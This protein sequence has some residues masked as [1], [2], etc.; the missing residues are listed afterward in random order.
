MKTDKLFGVHAEALQLRG[1]RAEVLAANLANVDTPGYKSRDFDFNAVLK[2][3]EP[4]LPPTVTDAGHIQPQQELVAGT[5][6][7]YR[8]PLQ[9]ALDGNTVD[10]QLE[11]GSFASNSLEYQSSLKFLNGRIQTLLLAIKGQ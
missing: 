3:L 2:G 1:H 5:E 7:Q 10:S 9:P 11:Y 6:L 8:V 4:N